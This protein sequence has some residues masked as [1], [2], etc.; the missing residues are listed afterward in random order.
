M[1]G[2]PLLPCIHDGFNLTV[3]VA[4]HSVT[5]IVDGLISVRSSE[6]LLVVFSVFKVGI[7]HNSAA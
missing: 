7:V 5:G 2:D 3:Y 4:V 1:K 6:C